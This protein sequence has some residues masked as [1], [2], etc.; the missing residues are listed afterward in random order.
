M[1]I[2]AQIEQVYTRLIRRG[3]DR[4][5]VHDA[6]VGLLV[7]LA[8]GVEIRNLESYTRQSA[9]YAFLR[10]RRRPS[11]E[12]G[13]QLRVSNP[14]QETLAALSELPLDLVIFTER[15]SRGRT[16]AQQSRLNRWRERNGHKRER[17]V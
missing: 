10:S 1:T 6:I 7:K 12:L 13:E 11:I 5:A 4:D 8:D 15:T 16:K 17:T 3:F 2:E 9:F 14:E